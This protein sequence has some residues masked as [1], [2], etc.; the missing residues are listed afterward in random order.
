MKWI[1]EIPARGLRFFLQIGFSLLKKFWKILSL[2]FAPVFRIIGPRLEKHPGAV[3]SLFSVFVSLFLFV[4][5][6]LY[7]LDTFLTSLIFQ[8]G[9]KEDQ[10]QKG[11]WIV[12]KDE[13]TS[14]LIAKAISRRD[15]ASVLRQIG[16]KKNMRTQNAGES[17]V[18][19]QYKFLEMK[20]GLLKG[21]ESGL[22]SF[23]L[24]FGDSPELNPD[25]EGFFSISENFARLF[26][27][28]F[29]FPEFSSR[30][31]PEIFSG[32]QSSSPLEL[33]REG[34]KFFQNKIGRA[35]V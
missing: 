26:R 19:R 3:F 33:M 21:G 18:I 7:D 23:P 11:I 1:L 25:E 27:D 35:H 5:G 20:V 34:C 32:K 2:L 22:F 4:S 8:V 17:D 10:T 16:R 13:K 12:K 31:F 29:E 30:T 15:F 28:L 9:Y 24:L 6:A 14:S